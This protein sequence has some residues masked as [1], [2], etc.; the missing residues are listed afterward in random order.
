[1][2]ASSVL[3]KKNAGFW[4]STRPLSILFFT[5]LEYPP[6][7]ACTYKTY[8]SI[9]FLIWNII[10]TCF[11]IIFILPGNI[12]LLLHGVWKY[13]FPANVP[14]L[15]GRLNYSPLSTFVSVMTIWMFL[16]LSLSACS[17]HCMLLCAQQIYKEDEREKKP[18][19][20]LNVSS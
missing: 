12:L 1:M 11:F 7:T 13:A 14:L 18:L 15:A 8:V 17:S 2:L 4:R 10:K 19:P 3:R 6:L 16:S 5:T 9:N 20:Q